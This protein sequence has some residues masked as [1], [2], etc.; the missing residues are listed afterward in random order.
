MNPELKNTFSGQ[1]VLIVDDDTSLLKLLNLRLT[2]LN[3]DVK[4]ADNAPEAIALVP[5]FQPQLVITDLR[6]DNMDGMSLF[7]H[8][9]ESNIHLPVIIL[10]AHGTIKEAV[11]AT[12]EGVFGF[13]TKP[14]ESSE[15]I[16]LITK[17]LKQNQQHIPKDSNATE[18]PADHS[19]ITRNP[20]MESL[21]Q[22]VTKVAANDVSVF[23][24]GE[25]GTGKELIAKAVHQ[26]SNRHAAE[27]IAVNCSAIPEELLESELFGHVKGA[28]S[29]ATHPRKGLFEMADEGSLFLDEIGDMPLSFQVK[30]LRVLQ[31]NEI[32][33]VGAEKN[34]KINVRLISASHH[35]LKQLTQENKFRL[36]LYYR[37]NVV[38]LEVPRLAERIE[39]IPLLARHFMVRFHSNAIAKGFSPEAMELLMSNDW[40]GNVRQLGNVIDYVCTFATTPII[41]VAL[42][43]KALEAKP[44]HLL[45]FNDAKRN[46]EREYLVRLLQ[47]TNGN[48][49]QA[50]KLAKRNRT[51]FYRI[52]T[53]HALKA[54]EFKV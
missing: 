53:K 14:F 19:I 22:D 24:H 4:S 29:G 7:R 9:Q 39:D 30:L 49:A 2:A 28:F 17:A 1:R 52:L 46:F 34:K 13:L 25:S 38:T 54:S 45:G 6:M 43:E 27:F 3:L 8:I 12:H 5:V 36:D 47:M 44:R 35:S 31:E 20:A 48:V 42:V 23:I 33:P 18:N 51:E 10:T 41:P 50:A 37:L 26:A 40:P 11:E 15:L 32:R 16:E 21:L